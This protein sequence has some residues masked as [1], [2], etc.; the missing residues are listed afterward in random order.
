MIKV[1][2]PSI[3]LGIGF[4][5]PKGIAPL[6]GPGEGRYTH[7]EIFEI[8]KTHNGEKRGGVL[9]LVEGVASCSLSDNFCKDTGRKIA[10]ARALSKLRKQ[11]P[12]P[13]TERAMIWK[14]YRTRN[15]SSNRDW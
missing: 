8:L 10:L 7:C 9:F 12:L 14:A 1:Q 15:E 4:S 6:P 3:T 5:H 13:K 2:L 11:L